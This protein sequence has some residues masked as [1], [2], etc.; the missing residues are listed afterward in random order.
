MG[1]MPVSKDD[2]TSRVLPQMV[3]SERSNPLTRSHTPLSSDLT[4][5]EKAAARFSVKGNAIVTGGCGNLGIEA[6]RALL[7]H[8]ASG[9][10]LFDVNPAQVQ[11]VVDKLCSDFPSARVTTRKVDVRDQQ[12]VQAAVAETAAELGSV[13]ILLCF[14]GVVACNHALDVAL[15][16]WK[17]TLDINTTGSWLCAQAAAKQMIK[18]GTGGSIVFTASISGHSVNFPQPQVSYNVS[19]GALLQ[20]KSSLAAEWAR[21]GIRV[22]SI[23]PGYMDTILNEGPG[24]EEARNLWYSRNPMGRMGDP[25]ELTGVVVLLCSRAGRYINGADIIVDGGGSVF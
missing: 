6:A 23:S 25:S 5:A 10:S 11:D 9:V 12:V 3:L 18:Q 2:L 21:Y 24:L 22:N 20:L 19:K 13:D 17:R 1:P 15:D 7:E 14:A 8:G 4:V 16:E